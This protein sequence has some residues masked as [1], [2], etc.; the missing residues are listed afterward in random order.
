MH[1]VLAISFV[2]FFHL[3]V[4]VENRK[5]NE[6]TSNEQTLYHKLRNMFN[7]QTLELILS[8]KR[9]TEAG[10]QNR[11]ILAVCQKTCRHL[12]VDST[13]ETLRLPYKQCRDDCVSDIIALLSARKCS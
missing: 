9:K 13:D 12:R 1:L 7:D 3:T 8:E 10:L 6:L 2:L 5:D 11:D 4:V